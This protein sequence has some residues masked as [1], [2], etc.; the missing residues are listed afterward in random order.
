MQRLLGALAGGDHSVPRGEGADPDAT[1][2]APADGTPISVWKN[3]GALGATGDF[4]A[5]VGFEP[6]YNTTGANP[7][8]SFTADPQ[9]INVDQAHFDVLTN[10]LNLSGGAATIIVAG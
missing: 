5:A 9:L 7:V 8:V 1:G 6:A 10:P 3:K 2:T 4:S